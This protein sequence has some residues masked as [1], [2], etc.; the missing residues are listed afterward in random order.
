MP[1]DL[2]YLPQKDWDNVLKEAAKLET[3]IV[4]TDDDDS[5]GI[6]VEVGDIP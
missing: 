2:H 6:V 3:I 4:N 1:D 5:D